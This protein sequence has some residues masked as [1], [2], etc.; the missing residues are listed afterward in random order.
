MC[1]W[2]WLNRG[3]MMREDDLARVR[4]PFAAAEDIDLPAGMRAGGAALP[5]PADSA[6]PPERVASRYPLNDFGNGQRFVTYFGDQVMWVPR[7]GWFTWTGQV[8]QKDPDRIATR[9]MAQQVAGLIAKETR[10]LEIPPRDAELL[11]QE[12]AIATELV[13]LSRRSKAEKTDAEMIRESSLKKMTA[14]I[15]KLKTGEHSVIGRRL[16]FA[17]ASG[18]SGRIDALLTEGGIALARDLDSLDAAEMDVNT[19]SG[20]L[21]FSV[22]GGPDQGFSRTADVQLLPHDRAHL[23]TKMMPVVYDPAA[24]CP[25]FDAFF[26]EVQPDPA[27]RAFILR[28]LGLSMTATPVQ[29]LAFWYGAGANGKSVLADLVARMLGDY[30]ATARIKSLTGV[31]RRGG[32]DATPDLMLLIGARFVRASEP[33]EGEP[34]QEELIKELTGGEQIMVRALNSDFVEMTPYF[35]L[36]ISGNHKVVVRGTDDG[37]WRRLLL[38]PWDVQIPEGRRDKDLGDKLFAQE[39]SGILNRLRDGLLDYLE[40]GLAV[41]LLVS[42]ATK[43]FREESDPVGTFLDQCC[44]ITGEH[45]DTIGAR[46][47]GEAFNFWNSDRGFGEWKPKTVGMKLKE[48]AGRWKSRVTNQC[49]TARKSSSNYYDGIQFNAVF[50]QRWKDA[51]RDAQGLVLRGRMEGGE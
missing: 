7:L 21:R 35:K 28:W 4:A 10:W 31:D 38:V 18:N 44:V 25:R 41:P 2:P 50:G 1:C 26:A 8:W 27:M 33:R 15:G 47:L 6:E 16:A 23:M 3:L 9:R 29:M 34:L 37:I 24:T 30:A 48:K 51:P 40:G 46:E 17:Q 36:T 45:R 5:P 32:G 39:R 20:V 42:D 11:A 49:F 43:E 12:D 22:S 19:E 14:R 13:A